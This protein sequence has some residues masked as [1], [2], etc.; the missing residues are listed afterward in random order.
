MYETCHRCQAELPQHD[1]GT[2]IFC[3]HCGAAQVTLSEEL[4]TQSD[5]QTAL[6]QSAQT[7]AAA[8]SDRTRVWAI[9]LRCVALAAAISFGLLIVSMAIPPAFLIALLWTVISPVVVLGL[10]QSRSPL[11]A[12]TLSFGARL[13]LVTG[14]A[15]A[16]VF[17]V[18]MTIV[19]VTLRFGTHAM[20]QFDSIMT[21]R[22]AQLRTQAAAQQPGVPLPPWLTGT[23]VPEFRAG[24]MLLSI[25][26]T[27]CML[28]TLTTA[29]GAFAGFLRSQKRS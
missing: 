5:A 8:P 19:M 26:F 7:A 1:E 20:A 24:L 21:D 9:A 4:Q 6:S 10:F 18:F 3:T 13:G 12:I 16:A 22:F 2:L 25:A 23:A 15:M 27:I 14:L 28:L 17:S 29:G 11:M